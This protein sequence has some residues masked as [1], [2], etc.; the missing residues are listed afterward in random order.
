MPERG[1]ALRVLHGVG[2][3]HYSGQVASTLRAAIPAGSPLP[4]WYRVQPTVVGHVQIPPTYAW[5]LLANA[6]ANVQSLPA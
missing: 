3:A 1:G 5:R 6:A 2:T 4:R